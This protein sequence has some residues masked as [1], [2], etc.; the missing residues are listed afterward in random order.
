MLQVMASE[1][2]ED[3]IHYVLIAR[4]ARVKRLEL[5]VVID[6]SAISMHGI[7][8]LLRKGPTVEIEI[9]LGIIGNL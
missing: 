2:W 5:S 8:G 9:I 1:V 7:E 4:E 6:H 3:L